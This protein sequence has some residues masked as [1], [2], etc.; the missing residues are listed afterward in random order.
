MVNIEIE[1]E[2]GYDAKRFERGDTLR[3]YMKGPAAV[4][5]PKGEIGMFDLKGRY[6]GKFKSAEGAKV[7]FNLVSKAEHAKIT[8]ISPTGEKIYIGD[9]N[10][11]V[12][13]T[14]QRI[15]LGMCLNNATSLIAA[16][17]DAENQPQNMVQQIFDLTDELYA[18]YNQR[19]NS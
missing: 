18:E 3:Y 11:G 12:M 6:A 19:Y 9:R 5:N 2:D 1:C 14:Q 8:L 17:T 16:Q 15:T 7:Q 13:S 10:A 4:S